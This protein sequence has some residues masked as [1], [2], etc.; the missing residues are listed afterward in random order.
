MHCLTSRLGQVARH[1]VAFAQNMM[2]LLKDF[3]GV[4]IK[5][6]HA[7]FIMKGNKH[8]NPPQNHTEHDKDRTSW[9]KHPP[10]GSTRTI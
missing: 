10:A 6:R 1:S 3:G 7:R 4:K 2:F 8:K 9:H 5:Q